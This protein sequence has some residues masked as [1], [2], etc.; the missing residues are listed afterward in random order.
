MKSSRNLFLLKCNQGR[1]PIDHGKSHGNAPFQA[2]TA[3]KI[4]HWTLESLVTLDTPCR[5]DVTCACGNSQ[6]SFSKQRLN[7]SIPNAHEHKAASFGFLQS[8]R[9]DCYM[10]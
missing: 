4:V 10:N 5:G 7:A 8:L 6:E 3:L 9:F 1:I 2:M